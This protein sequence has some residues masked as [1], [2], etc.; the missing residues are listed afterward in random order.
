M[1]KAYLLNIECQKLKKE[2]QKKDTTIA[3]YKVIQ[4]DNLEA[5]K[6]H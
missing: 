2:L 1:G 6:F 3:N 4:N 5:I